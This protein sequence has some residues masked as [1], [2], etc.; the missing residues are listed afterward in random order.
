MLA[1]S[2]GAGIL[3]IRSRGKQ[4]A[5]RATIDLLFER[6]LEHS[7]TVPTLK[8]LIDSGEVN[9]AQY[10]NQPTS[11]KYKSITF[12]LNSHEFIAA[13]IK[14][15]ALSDEVYKRMRFSAVMRDWEAAEGFI[16]EFRK[17]KQKQ[18][19]FQDFEWLHRQ[20]KKKP[21]QINE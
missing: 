19:L 7:N 8:E 18:T 1:I 14:T 4:E 15:H 9:L 6:D 16:A 10:A 13:G 21:L 5:R 17:I 3:V 11:E 20:W 2:A 12:A